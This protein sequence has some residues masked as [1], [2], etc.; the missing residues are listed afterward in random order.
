MVWRDPPRSDDATAAM[1]RQIHDAL[2]RHDEASAQLLELALRR[3]TA[4][5][6]KYIDRSGSIQVANA[7]QLLVADNPNRVVLVFM[8]V[9]AQNLG[10][11]PGSQPAAIGQAGTLTIVPAGSWV[12]DTNGFIDTSQWSVVGIAQGLAYTCFEA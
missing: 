1:L 3:L 10:I 7:S 11:R 5:R 9:S 4:V 2:E 8:N 6:G 12:M